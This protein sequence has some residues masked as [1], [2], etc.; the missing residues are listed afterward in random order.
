M[1]SIT[2]ER[3][4]SPIST[5]E[6]QRRW[7]AVSDFMD[8]RGI[9][10]LLVRANNDYLGGYVKWF[11]DL[12]ASTGYPVTLIFPRGGGMSLISQGT[13]GLDRSPARDDPVFRGVTRILGAPGYAS[14]AYT[15]EYECEAVIRAL[16]P[17][18]PGT[19]G[20]VGPA[21]IPYFL[22]DRLRSG[23]PGIRELV[24]A[25]E[26]VDRIKCIKS[27][28]EIQRILQTARL[29]DECMGAVVA[30]IRPGMR[31]FE[32][33]AAAQKVAQELGSE[34]GVY[35]VASAPVGVPAVYG[36]RHYQGRAIRE[37]DYLNV[38]IETNGA[39][40]YYTEL[41]RMCVVGE[42]G[43]ELRHAMDFVAAAQD[44]AADA[45]RP[46]VACS[47][48]WDRYNAFVRS[49]GYPEERRLFSHGQGYDLVER[50]LVRHDESM[51][52]EA[53]MNLAC[54]PTFASERFFCSAC[55]NFLVGEQGTERIHEF[56]RGMAV[57]G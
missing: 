19:I 57:I 34:Q 8:E 3:L 14:V 11:T 10:V 50:P 41:G 4:L 1:N 55:D 44:F 56:P 29:Q 45:L 43:E 31:D 52:I 35:L 38:L 5:A 30:Q 17:F 51:R 18:Q 42:P 36:I 2:E 13:F 48:I 21:N 49:H 26:W 32:V 20:V 46:G 6:L 54:H 27:A 53:G 28:E 24:D 15:A 47:E 9:Q 33:S 12:P 25:T 40:G 7:D 37:G 23:I 16:E 39:G 22:A